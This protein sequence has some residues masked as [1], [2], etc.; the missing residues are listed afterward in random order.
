MTKL[1]QFLFPWPHRFEL[2]KKHFKVWPFYSTVS[3]LDYKPDAFDNALCC[4]TM[5]ELLSYPDHKKTFEEVCLDRAEELKLLDGTIYVMWSGGIDSTSILTAIFRTFSRADLD[6]VIVLCD[7][8]SIK[9]NANYFKLIIKN[10]VKVQLSTAELEPLLKKGWIITGE[11][12]DQIFG[13]DMVMFAVYKS[14]DSAMHENWE[15]HVPDVFESMVPGGAKYIY[16]VVSPI[17]NE[18][19]FKIKTVH[20][21]GWWYNISQKW[22]HVKLRF[23]T[24]SKWEDPKNNYAKLIH[25]Y[26]SVDF[27]LWS[28]Y[29]N[30]EK[31]GKKFKTYKNVS[32]EFSITWSKDFDFINKEKETSA[33]HLYLGH[34]MN[35]AIDENWNFL[36][37][38][39]ALKRIL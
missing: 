35:W 34:E 13:H 29:G 25:F 11:L 27:Q 22:Q 15:K 33:I 10:K 8:R 30:E 7:D 37:K 14:G 1:L 18:A 39:E 26:D 9:E 21:F 19:P 6:R 3:R 24:S 2:P 28:I 20:E 38:E 36:S 31:V 5:K 23:L 17:I 16:E 12:G 4:Q 32:K